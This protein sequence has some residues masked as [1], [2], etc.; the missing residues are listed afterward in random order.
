M[1]PLQRNGAEYDGPVGHRFRPLGH[2]F[3]N[4]TAAEAAEARL[5]ARR[6]GAGCG[7]GRIAL[8]PR[9]GA[10]LV[11]DAGDGGARDR[12]PTAA[13]SASVSS[14]AAICHAQQNTA[15]EVVHHVICKWA[16]QTLA[17]RNLSCAIIR[18][19]LGCIPPAGP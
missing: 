12:L 18:A 15:F 2:H 14:P 17:L 8:P 13:R 1:H 9:A 6:L 3:R 16:D 4:P 5:G 7:F 19:Y 10:L 11:D